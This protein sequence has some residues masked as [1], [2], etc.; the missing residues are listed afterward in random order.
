MFKLMVS[1]NCG[2]TYELDMTANI[3][4]ELQLRI[5]YCNKMY[6]RYYVESD[7]RQWVENV[8]CPIHAEMVNTMIELN[9]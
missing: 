7:D 5:S 2:M 1:W 8:L 9:A 6:L 3:I 4:D